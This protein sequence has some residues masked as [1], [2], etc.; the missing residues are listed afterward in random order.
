MLTNKT[1][2]F[3]SITNFANQTS[4]LSCLDYISLILDNWF[5]FL[6]TFLNHVLFVRFVLFLGGI[7][8]TGISF[9][10]KMMCTVYNVFFL[11]QSKTYLFTSRF[12]LPAVLL[13]AV[14]P[15]IFH[16]NWEIKKYQRWANSPKNSFSWVRRN[17]NFQ[18]KSVVNRKYNLRHH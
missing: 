18:R 7:Y 14:M 9:S 5:L 8:F 16:G 12:L 15:T 11:Q 1:N 13:I 6:I 4:Q 10:I 3:W 2:L 17:Q